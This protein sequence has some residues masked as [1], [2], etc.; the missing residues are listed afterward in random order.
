MRIARSYSLAM[1]L[2]L[3]AQPL[4]AAA[5]AD[6]G[7]ARF[8]AIYKELIETDTSLSNGDCTLAAAAPADKGEARFRAIY[9]E[10]IET[11]TSLSNG[12]CTLAASRMRDRLVAGGYPE[13][14]FQVIIPPGFPK[15]GNLVGELSGSNAK[16]PA[17]L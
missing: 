10:L 12:D 13:G 11:D 2:A 17:V 16:L 3:A 9:K 4:A 5:P 14:Q 15:S 7:E 8:R 6:K 1:A